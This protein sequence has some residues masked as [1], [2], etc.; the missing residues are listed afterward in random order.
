LAA[1][2][3]LLPTKR[4]GAF[5]SRRH[6]CGVVQLEERTMSSTDLGRRSLRQHFSLSNLDKNFANNPFRHPAPNAPA[7]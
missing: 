6:Q 4:R 2:P 3:A 5:R 1:E 7:S